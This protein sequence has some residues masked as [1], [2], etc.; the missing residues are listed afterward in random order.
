MRDFV[1]TIIYV[2]D[3]S[4]FFYYFRRP[5]FYEFINIKKRTDQEGF[6]K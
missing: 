4:L 2:W 1:R 3:E 6:E 5:S